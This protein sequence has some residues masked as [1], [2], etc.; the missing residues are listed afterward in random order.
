M[1][2]QLIRMAFVLTLLL[3]LGAIFGGISSTSAHAASTSSSGSLAAAKPNINYIDCGGRGDFV[4]IYSTYGEFCYA[5][6]G[7]FSISIPGV[8]EV[9]GG[10]NTG[11]VNTSWGH[12]NFSRWQ[13]IVFSGGYTNVFFVLIN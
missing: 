2:N 3:A 10:N 1:K 6:A 7:G 5:N 9:C 12:Y 4:Q 11:Y 13:C 8:Y